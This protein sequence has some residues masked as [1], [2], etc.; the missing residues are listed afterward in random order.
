MELK[1]F[2]YLWTIQKEIHALEKLNEGEYVISSEPSIQEQRVTS[3]VAPL[4]IKL[5]AD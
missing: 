4:F 5:K 1:D 2:E 3:A